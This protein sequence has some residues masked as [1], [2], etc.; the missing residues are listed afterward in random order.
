MTY[1][2][3]IVVGAL[4]GAAIGYAVFRFIGCRSGACILIGN[5][6]VPTVMFGVMGA[7]MAAGK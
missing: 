6:V 5:P 4:V 1:T 3:K 2:L 7:L